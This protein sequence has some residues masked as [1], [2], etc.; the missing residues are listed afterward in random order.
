LH[1]AAAAAASLGRDARY[2]VSAPTASFEDL[3]QREIPRLPAHREGHR[4]ATR[5]VGVRALHAVVPL[6]SP[7]PALR[8]A[9]LRGV[10]DDALRATS[11]R[12][13]LPLVHRESVGNSRI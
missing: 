5:I 12:R 2:G 4:R 6:A 11:L 1:E 13:V 8:S 10:G 7:P 9:H 3:L